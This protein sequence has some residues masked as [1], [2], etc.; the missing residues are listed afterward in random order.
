[1]S[2]YVRLE[3]LRSGLSSLGVDQTTA[4]VQDLRLLVPGGLVPRGVDLVFN[5]L[6]AT[7]EGALHPY[8]RQFELAG[9]PVA[10]PLS[11]WVITGQKDATVQILAGAGVPVPQTVVG[12]ADDEPEAIAAELGGFPVIIKRS[13]GLKGRGVVICETLRSFRSTLQTLPPAPETL[14]FQEFISESSGRDYKFTVSRDFCFCAMARTARTL[15]EFRANVA[16][17]GQATLVRP[18]DDVA[19]IAMRA[20]GALGLFFGAV[21]IV[22]S[23]RGPLVIDVGD[24][25]ELNFSHGD[26][27]CFVETDFARLFVAHALRA[28][29]PE[30]RV[31]G[32]AIDVVCGGLPNPRMAV[33]ED[34]SRHLTAE[35][36]LRFDP[37]QIRRG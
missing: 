2:T 1:V 28:A 8:V 7:E 12:T 35:R 9:I 6:S 19:E 24:L 27:E 15:G 13:R 16:L 20:I 25:P 26:L 32:E 3:A 37:Q 22:L 29:L 4:R 36:V 31:L 23:R 14:V 21:D 5:A 10:N 17:G 11:G 33:G 34:Y 18:E 30:A